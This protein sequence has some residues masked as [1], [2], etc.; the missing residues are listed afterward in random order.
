MAHSSDTL[1]VPCGSERGETGATFLCKCLMI[2]IDF[3]TG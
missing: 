2:Y 3:L 1:I